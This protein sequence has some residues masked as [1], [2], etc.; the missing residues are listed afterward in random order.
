MT[1]QDREKS[2]CCDIVLA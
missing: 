1:C 2:P